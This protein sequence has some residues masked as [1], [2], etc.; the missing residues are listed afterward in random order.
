MK[1]ECLIISLISLCE[2]NRAWVSN[3]I[4]P[5]GLWVNEDGCSNPHIKYPTKSEYKEWGDSKRG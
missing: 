4:E 1:L 3:P 5:T 2:N